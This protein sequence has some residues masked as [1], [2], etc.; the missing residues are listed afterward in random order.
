MG[1]SRDMVGTV[2][3]FSHKHPTTGLPRKTLPVGSNW[4]CLAAVL[5]LTRRAEWTRA[6]WFDALRLFAWC[7]QILWLTGRWMLRAFLKALNR[8][9][10]ALEGDLHWR[11]L[12]ASALNY[13]CIVA[14]EHSAPFQVPPGSAV[15]AHRAGQ[16]FSGLLAVG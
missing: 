8:C 15:L 5:L 16:V 7:I 2:E 11:Q 3:L 1:H 9:E 6:V 10:L 13:F 14:N 4:R 12:W